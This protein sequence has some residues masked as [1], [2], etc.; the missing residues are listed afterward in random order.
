MVPDEASVWGLGSY[1]PTNTRGCV[2][3]RSLLFVCPTEGG[4]EG[5]RSAC[6]SRKKVIALRSISASYNI[7]YTTA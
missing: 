2:Y 1:L 7:V 6:L 3:D 5:V 4:G